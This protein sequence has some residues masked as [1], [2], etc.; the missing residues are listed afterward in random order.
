MHQQAG[1]LTRTRSRD[2]FGLTRPGIEPED[3]NHDNFY[4]LKGIK[5]AILM[6]LKKLKRFFK[7]FEGFKQFK[8]RK[9]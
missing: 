1:A 7:L 5:I 2:F 4:D 9:L 3:C 8:L 6:S